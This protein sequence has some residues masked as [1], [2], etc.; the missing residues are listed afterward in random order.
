MA[1][2]NVA[3]ISEVLATFAFNAGEKAVTVGGV[4]SG[5]VTVADCDVADSDEITPDGPFAET[6]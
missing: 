4:T 5:G 1:S 2:L 6:A 3:S